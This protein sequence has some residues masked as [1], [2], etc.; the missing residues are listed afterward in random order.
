MQAENK[1]PRT[2]RHSSTWMSRCIC[3]R[4]ENQAS[5]F[6]G[7]DTTSDSIYSSPRRAM[8]AP[9]FTR[10]HVD[11]MRPH[12]QRT[13]D[14]LLDTMLKARGDKAVD[15]V[16]KFSLP[17]PSYVRALFLFWGTAQSTYYILRRIRVCHANRSSTVSWEFR[18]RTLSTSLS[19]TPSE[20]MEVLLRPRRQVQISTLLT[21]HP[22]HYFFFLHS[23]LW[24][25]R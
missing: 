11:A 24:Q 17:V 6:F 2:S 8:L 22:C 12:I 16:D 14:S 5:D 1:Q 9:L 3:S 20:A 15:L 13:V 25:K 7:D 4:G 19:A 10:E 21:F 23:Q 18:S